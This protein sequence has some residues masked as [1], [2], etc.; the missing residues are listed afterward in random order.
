MGERKLAARC[1]TTHQFASFL[2]N[3]ALSGILGA[4]FPGVEPHLLSHFTPKS[5]Q[6]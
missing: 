2:V 6:D 5:P 4:Q 1:S 3:H